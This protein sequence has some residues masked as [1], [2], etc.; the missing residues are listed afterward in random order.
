MRIRDVRYDDIP[1][2]KDLFERH[3]FAYEFPDF[4]DGS[5]VALQAI[6]DDNDKVVMVAAARVMAELYLLAD[7]TFETPGW[8]FAALQKLHE[9]MRRAL[10]ALGI[11]SVASWLPPEVEKT[12][13]RRLMRS[14]GWNKMFW[15]S[16]SRSTS[17]RRSE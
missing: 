13:G 1:R 10:V 8:R 4:G 12:F 7:D 2:I 3:K 15:N 17:P 14:F 5:F 16:Y 6:V 9:S 11:P